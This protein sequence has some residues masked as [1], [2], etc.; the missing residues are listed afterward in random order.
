MKR[1]WMVGWIVSVA[2]AAG[3]AGGGVGRAAQIEPVFDPGNFVAAVN[4]PFFPLEPG[5]TFYYAGEPDEGTE[6]VEMTV[7]R[8]T[9]RILGVEAVVVVAREY[10]DGELVEETD[11]WYAQDR[12]GNVWYLGED[13]RHY[14]DGRL[15]GTEGSW[16]AGRDGARAGTIM[17]AD[18]EVGDTY[19]QEYYAGVAEDMAKVVSLK[20]TAAVP[21]GVFTDCLETMDWTPL[22]PGARENKFYARGVGMV[23]EVASAGGKQ[24]IE[25]TAVTRR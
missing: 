9:K 22:E 6:T 17:L 5:T 8:Q 7:T 3:A 15:V 12:Q 24:R 13:S 1:R 11:D 14:E 21:H 19:Q 25:L 18:P 2:V 20:S 10:L 16:E 23:L 4:H